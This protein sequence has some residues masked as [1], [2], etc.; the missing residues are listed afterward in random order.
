M[1]ADLSYALRTAASGLVA[2]QRALDTVAN[3]VANVNTPGFSRKVV[4]FESRV[5]SGAGAGVQLGPLMRTIDDGLLKSIRLEQGTLGALS[6]Q[7]GLFARIS[8]LF[9]SPEANT[10]LSHD[11]AE[12]E[13]AFSALARAPHDSIEQR[14]AVRRADDLALNLRHASATIQGLRADADAELVRGVGE[15]NTLVGQIGDLTETIVR[16]TAVGRGTADIEDQRDRA[17]DQLSGL[18]DIR[19]FTRGGGDIAVFT[20]SGRALVSTAARCRS[21]IRASPLLM[22]LPT[23]PRATSPPSPPAAAPPP[24]TSPAISAAAASPG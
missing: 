14:E 20:A 16:D 24:R 21:V 5:S 13:S 7:S 3:N 10:S 1:A 2:N 17:L 6:A 12:L 15:I 22:R 9:G 4:R 18:I 19:V 8:D 11:L 23:T